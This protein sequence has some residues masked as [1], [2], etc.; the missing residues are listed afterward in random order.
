MPVWEQQE[1]AALLRAIREGS[2]TAFAVLV[3]RHARRFYSVAYRFTARREDAEDIVQDVFLKLWE[4]PE[5]WQPEK[6]AKFTTWF[7]RVVVNRCL[8]WKK[9]KTPL[10]LDDSLPIEDG[11]EG[12]EEVFIRS[13]EQALLERAIQCLPERQ[14]VAL[15]LCFYEA[16]SNQEAAEIME[17]NVKALQSLLM[18]AKTTLK[19]RIGGMNRPVLQAPGLKKKRAG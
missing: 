4:Q 6:Q 5:S 10:R 15:N 1:D 3:R 19:E 7:Y 14:R 16:L 18:R 13:E 8:D 2:P 9:H 12:A 11:R 17:V